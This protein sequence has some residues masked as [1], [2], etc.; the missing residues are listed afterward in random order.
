MVLLGL[1][2]S[3][4]I[5]CEAGS[6]AGDWS[7]FVPRGELSLVAS[8]AIVT[9]YEAS[10]TSEVSGATRLEID[11]GD[12]PLFVTD[13]YTGAD[14]LRVPLLGVW[15][16]HTFTARL[17]DEEGGLIARK[18]FTTA[19]GPTDLSRMNVS[20]EATW[21]GYLV[22]EIATDDAQTVVVLA[23][24]GQPVWYW[25]FSGEYIGRALVRRDGL[26]VWVL[27][28]AGPEAGSVGWIGA[29][30]WD[31]SM[32]MAVTPFGH[33]GQGPTHDILELEDG[34]LLFLGPE[35]RTVD[36]VA[37]TGN[38]LFA[39]E[40]DG[41]ERELWSYWDDFTPDE[42]TPDPLFWT[43]ANAL[44]WNEARE[45][46]WIGSRDLSML[47]ELDSETWRPVN[48]L[49]GSEPTFH[50]GPTSRL[51]NGQH[52]FDFRDGRIAVH[53]NRDTTVGTRLV[54]YDLD[55][56]GEHPLAEQT[57]EYVPAPPIYDFVLGDVT[58]LDDERV[59]MTW[60]TTGILEERNLDGDAPWSIAL[61]LGS[62]F[63]YTQHVAGLPGCFPVSG[64]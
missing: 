34:R 6:E 17:V 22:T 42:R 53:D 20:G 30:A 40:P 39:L 36:D 13:W 23:P 18:A 4:L 25:S 41:S 11:D 62:I 26:G 16:S 32:L 12:E 21:E 60:S 46:L 15:P 44:R 14:V 35:T 31:G 27:G 51:P 8:E 28:M 5:G 19:A 50:L 43:H 58:W 48:Q 63:P 37:Y 38:T 7:D 57:F 56:A 1:L 45:T 2:V 52:Q 54:I 24:N 55:F 3:A 9:Y 10:W 59:I 47:V 61:D 29:V 33:E 49:G 64:G